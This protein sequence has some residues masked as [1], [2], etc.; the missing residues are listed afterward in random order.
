MSQ[1][2]KHA[3]SAHMA[4]GS[5]QRRKIPVLIL[6]VVGIFLA[7]LIFYMIADRDPKPGEVPANTNIPATSTNDAM[8]STA[9]AL[10]DTVNQGNTATASDR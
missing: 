6:I 3:A 2:F 7:S 9:T 10:D 4:E 5:N 8:N 1:D